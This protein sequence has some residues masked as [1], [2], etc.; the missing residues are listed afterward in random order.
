[1]GRGE[2]EAVNTEM[3]AGKQEQRSGG[4]GLHLPPNPTCLREREK[5]VCRSN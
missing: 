1:M 2:Q 3:A 5:W 4:G